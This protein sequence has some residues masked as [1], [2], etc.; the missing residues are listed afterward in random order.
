MP[1]R[2]AMTDFWAHNSARLAE[3]AAEIRAKTPLR[4]RGHSEAVENRRGRNKEAV[5]R[6]QRRYEEK[7]KALGIKRKR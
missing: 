5:R 1:E 2:L 7:R 3:I 6:A 4:E